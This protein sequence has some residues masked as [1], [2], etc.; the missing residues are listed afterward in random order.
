[1]VYGNYSKYV[2]QSFQKK[3]IMLYLSIYMNI[4]FNFLCGW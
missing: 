1:M 4:I 2:L 3:K